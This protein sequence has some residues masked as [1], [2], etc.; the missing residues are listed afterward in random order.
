MRYC[1]SDMLAVTM[2][3]F[4]QTCLC[5]LLILSRQQPQTHIWSLSKHDR[6]TVIFDSRSLF[7]NYQYP[8]YIPPV[9][10]LSAIYTQSSPLWQVPPTLK[11]FVGTRLA[12]SFIGALYSSRIAQVP[13]PKLDWSSWG[14]GNL[15]RLWWELSD[16]AASLCLYHVRA[17]EGRFHVR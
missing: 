1:V 7:R 9:L 10:S 16:C 2:L 17:R 13:T 6:L 3:N 14:R 12:T 15:R 11:L 8:P 5:L 4:V